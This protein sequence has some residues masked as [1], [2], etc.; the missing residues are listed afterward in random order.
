MEDKAATEK[1][2]RDVSMIPKDLALKISVPKFA[3]IRTLGEQVQLFEGDPLNRL[4]D[5]IL[6]EW[7]VRTVTTERCLH[8]QPIHMF[9]CT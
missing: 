6:H 7:Q 5:L 4:L 1:N 3:L 9:G 2:E 8:M